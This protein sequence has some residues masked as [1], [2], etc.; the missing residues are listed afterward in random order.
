LDGVRKD[1][2]I[3]EDSQYYLK[4]V[5]GQYGSLFQDDKVIY[6]FVAHELRKKADNRLPSL[7][8]KYEF[9]AITMSFRTRH[10]NLTS[11]FVSICAIVGGVFAVSTMTSRVG[12]IIGF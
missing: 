10:T 3:Q 7:V 4:V 5:G 2:K 11:L 1:N 6:T 8:F 9:D 12:E